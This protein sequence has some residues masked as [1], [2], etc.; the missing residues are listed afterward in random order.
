MLQNEAA[1]VTCS[2]KMTSHSI[3]SGALNKN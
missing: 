1:T 2:S 3:D